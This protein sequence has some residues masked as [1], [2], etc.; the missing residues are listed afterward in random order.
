MLLQT[1]SRIAI[2]KNIFIYSQ[3]KSMAC[4]KYSNNKLVFRQLVDNQ[5]NTFTYLLSDF[6]TKDAV[7]IDPV[8]EK[9]DR[10][11]KLI[12]EL[13]LNLKYAINTHVHADH[14][15]GSGMLKQ[16]LPIKSM[17][18][19]DSKAKADIY[20]K[21]GDKIEFGDSVLDCVSTPGHTN[22][23]MS[24]I[25]HSSKLV[26][27]GDAMLI[28]GC[29]RT[30]FQ[31]GDSNRLYDSIHQKILCLPD[32]YIVFP[33]HDYNGF[34]SSSIKEEKQ[35]NP[36]L[37]KNREEF[38]QLMNNLQLAYP[39]MI[40]KAVPANMVCGIIDESKKE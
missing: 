32:D 1:L 29:G 38:V 15:T 13:G 35:Y 6:N 21:D 3:I 4:A 28:R 11:V 33:G 34:T 5:T 20:I 16:K 36:R 25:S 7:I 24:F 31:Q 14:I 12:T 27:T 26:F 10:D 8:I 40:D 9:V 18:S 19:A 30:D 2:P 17:I 39:K 37:T 22:G 23:C